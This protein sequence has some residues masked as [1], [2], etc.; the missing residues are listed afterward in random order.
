MASDYCGDLMV[1]S[2]IILRLPC[3]CVPLCVCTLSFFMYI[4]SVTFV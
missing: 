4:G 3:M 1:L 2:F